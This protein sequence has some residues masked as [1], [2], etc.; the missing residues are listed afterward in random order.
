MTTA[1][2]NKTYTEEQRIEITNKVCELMKTGVACIKA[3]EQVGVKNSTFTSWLTPNSW[4]NEQYQHARNMLIERWA[5]EVITLPDARDD[6]YYTDEHGNKKYDNAAVNLT[7]LQVDSRKWVLSK[8]ASPR[9][10]DRVINEHVGA[11]GGAIVTANVDLT[12]LESS[13]IDNLESLMTKL[14]TAPKV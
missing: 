5:E 9:F 14:L 4:H 10:G 7:R 6:H 2:T 13:E 1:I 3:C 8:L 11:G 12:R